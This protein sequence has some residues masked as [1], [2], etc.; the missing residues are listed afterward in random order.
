M[1]QIRLWYNKARIWFLKRFT[2]RVKEVVIKD[3]A[4]GREV[5]ATSV[6]TEENVCDHKTITEIAP[7]LYKCAGCD[8]VYF[9]IMYKVLCMRPELLDYVDKIADHFQAKL[10]DK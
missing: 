3:E 10:T 7:T 5:K 8:E 1:E 2:D 4:T 9:M 6:Q